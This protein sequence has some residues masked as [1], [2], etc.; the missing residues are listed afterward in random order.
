M[1][2]QRLRATFRDPGD[3]E[4]EANALDLD[5]IKES[6]KSDKIVMFKCLRNLMKFGNMFASLRQIVTSCVFCFVSC[7]M[8][9]RLMKEDKL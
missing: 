2:H 8:V 5:M 6:L 3:L 4:A 7:E 9:D 1:N